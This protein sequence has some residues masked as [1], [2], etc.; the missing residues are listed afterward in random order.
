MSCL[1]RDVGGARQ[2][3]KNRV[4]RDPYKGFVCLWKLDKVVGFSIFL[5]LF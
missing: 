4:A 1:F 2:E 5:K 3:G